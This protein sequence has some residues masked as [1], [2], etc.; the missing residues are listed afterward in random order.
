MGPSNAAN[1]S[2]I[3]GGIIMSLI[4]F[5][6]VFLVC[7][8]LMG[9]MMSLKY[10]VRVFE[11]KER[12]SQSGGNPSA[13]KPPVGEPFLAQATPDDEGELVAVITAAVTA[14]FGSSARVTDIRP[15]SSIALAPPPT[16]SSVWKMAS[17]IENN[18]GI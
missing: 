5:S 18:K 11:E 4:S 15:S 13:A 8:G 10:V 17:R 14:A 1:F 7:A 3:N 2:G 9:L 16:F 12:Q 6:I